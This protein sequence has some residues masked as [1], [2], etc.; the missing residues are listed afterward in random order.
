MTVARMLQA[1]AAHV[2]D[3]SVDRARRELARHF[4]P[5]KLKVDEKDCESFRNDASEAEG[6]LPA[7]V[8]LAET[9]RDVELA[10]AAALQARAPIVPRAAGTGKTGGAVPVNGGIVLSMLGLSQIKEIDRRE[11][12]AVVEPGV[13]LGALHAAALREGLFYPPDP[14]SRVGCSIGGNV[15]T[16][17]GGPRAFKYGVTGRYVL[18]I[19]AFLVGGERVFTGRRTTKGVTGYDVTDH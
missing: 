6:E 17:A 13:I 1:C 4:G 5:S 11:S 18:G 9:S 3:G 16:N 12:V 7:A 14:N 8:V 2:V 19:E 15:A 10:L